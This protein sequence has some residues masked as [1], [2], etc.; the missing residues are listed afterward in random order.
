MEEQGLQSMMHWIRSATERNMTAFAIVF[1]GSTLL[2]FLCTG[3]SIWWSRKRGWVDLPNPRSLH[4]VPTPR[5]GGIGIVIAF[6]ASG[7]GVEAFGHIRISEFI[8]NGRSE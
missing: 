1:L 6:C 2:A 7:L 4:Y 3:L 5:I 8:V